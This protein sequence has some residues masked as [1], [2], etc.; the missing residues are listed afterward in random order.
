[1]ANERVVQ[2]LGM[3]RISK[4]QN[5]VEKKNPDCKKMELSSLWYLLAYVARF[6]IELWQ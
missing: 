3:V 4:K 5:F 6:T 2:A 1:M